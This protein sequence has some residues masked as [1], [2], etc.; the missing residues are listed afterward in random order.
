MKA[1]LKGEGFENERREEENELEVRKD[2]PRN[3]STFLPH[4]ILSP[5]F[6]LL[7]PSFT[8][9]VEIDFQE[10]DQQGY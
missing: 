1:D 10:R 6:S 5:L 8:R 4:Q 3:V 9:G 7:L 2:L